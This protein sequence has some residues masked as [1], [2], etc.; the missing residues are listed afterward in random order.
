M[1]LSA[2]LTKELY[3]LDAESLAAVS[4]I[5]RERNSDIQAAAR[6]QFRIGDYV[7]F[8][9]KSRGRG[10]ISGRIVK[11]NGKTI[12]VKANSGATWRVTPSLLTKVK[13]PVSAKA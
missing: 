5:I 11:I 4:A 7:R 2:A 3:N 13:E 6:S 12:K 1:K 10:I 8:D 9:A